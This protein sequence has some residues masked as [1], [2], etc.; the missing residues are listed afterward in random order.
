MDQ[1]LIFLTILGMAVVTYLPRLLPAWLLSSRRLNPAVERWLGFVPTAVLAAL[2]APGLVLGEEGPDFSLDNVFLLAAL[3]AF[4]V[5]V[6]TRS[7]FGTVA[8]GM[9]AVAL[10][11]LFSG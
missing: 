8:V 2:L 7:F 6:K 11:R 3:P 5:A 9:G 4:A 10:L 1:T